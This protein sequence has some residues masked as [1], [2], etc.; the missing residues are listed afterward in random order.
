MTN[1]FRQKIL[2]ALVTC[3]FSTFAVAEISVIVHPSNSA[4][5]D[6]KVISKLFLAK[7]KSFPGGGSAVPVNQADGEAAR[8]EFDDKVLGKSSSQLK[9]YWSKLIFTGK[10]TPPKD[11]ANDAAVKSL[12]SSNPNM[13]G[14]INSSAVDGSVKVVA[15][16]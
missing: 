3:C 5:L 11:I 12:I 10:G 15:T 4:A 16:F 14:Y 8:S 1:L 9:A 7:S 6:E 13:I 2:M